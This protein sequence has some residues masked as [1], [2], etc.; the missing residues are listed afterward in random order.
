MAQSGNIPE[1]TLPNDT[2]A[3]AIRDASYMSGGRGEVSDQTMT[4]IF[5]RMKRKVLNNRLWSFCRYQ[6]FADKGDF[7]QAEFN[8]GDDDDRIP[9]LGYSNGYTILYPKVINVYSINILNNPFANVLL[10]TPG[11]GLKAGLLTDPDTIEVDRSASK[12][13]KFIRPT[14]YSDQAIN[15]IEISRDV[16]DNKMTSSVLEYIAALIAEEVC[17]KNNSY[18]MMP[19]VIRIRRDRAY[20]ATIGEP[21]LE[22]DSK[23]KR[24][25]DWV[26]DREYERRVPF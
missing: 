10:D 3:A 1:A 14:I 9:D 22:R 11:R 24:D 7:V 5:Y 8:V 20:D 2:V 15:N 16:P 19:Y 17:R 21:V 26:V 18:N 4:S 13:F 12:A 25:I 23:L 6:L